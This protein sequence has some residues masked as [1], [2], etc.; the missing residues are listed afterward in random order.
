MKRQKVDLA[1]V[2]GNL[3]RGAD[4]RYQAATPLR[5]VLNK[6]FPDHW[7][8]LLGEIA[9]FSFIVLLLTGTFL[10]L[11][12]DP[13]MKE[14]PYDG[15]YTALRGTEMSGAYES[16]LRLSFEIRGGLFMR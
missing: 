16:S 5:A 10:T 4:E 11:F 3:A 2:P 7:S 8:F 12:F 9:L 6:V 1:Q 13:T 15:A 14:V